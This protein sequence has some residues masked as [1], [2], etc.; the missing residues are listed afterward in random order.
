L[1]A[2]A[3]AGA[4]APMARP[5]G[6]ATTPE[7][8]AWPVCAAS[9]TEVISSLSRDDDALALAG[10]LLKL[11]PTAIALAQLTD[12]IETTVPSFGA[13]AAAERTLLVRACDAARRTRRKILLARMLRE[14]RPAYL[15][16]ASFLRIPR[17]ELPNLQDVPVREWDARA[18][19]AA[20][21]AAAAASG[22]PELVPD[23]EL[24]PLAMGEGLLESALLRLTRNIYARET[25]GARRTETA[26]ILG[27]IE[28]MRSYMLS[29]AGAAPERQQEALI[30]TL[31]TLMTPALPPFYRVFMGWIVPSAE[32]GDP[33]WLVDGVQAVRTSHE[34]ISNRA[35]SATQKR[36][37]EL[38]S[39][40]A[41][42]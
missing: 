25:G 4:Y 9:D 5:L 28:E 10:A 1:A 14:D 19:P 30:R 35:R 40:H 31:R 39:K 21:A 36:S 41:L 20:A 8:R 12:A 22:D 24:P 26:G 38:Q 18:T 23:C 2:A 15:Q 37:F 42:F 32:R 17:S 6:P 33:R 13:A 16:T 7:R 27:L 34:T 3:S 29:E 11:E